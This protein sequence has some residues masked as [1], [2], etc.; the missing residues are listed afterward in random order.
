VAA[1]ID[2]IPQ[3]EYEDITL[4][5]RGPTSG[6]IRNVAVDNVTQVSGDRITS[7]TTF[8]SAL[9]KADGLPRS[10]TG[11]LSTWQVPII[12]NCDDLFT[13][14][15]KGKKGRKGKSKMPVMAID[16]VQ[17]I[18][19]EEEEDLCLVACSDLGK[20]NG[21]G[22]ADAPSPAEE[23]LD[24]ME[25]VAVEEAA[26]EEEKAGAKKPLVLKPKPVRPIGPD[27]EGA[28]N[29]TRR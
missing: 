9:T 14:T 4:P 19:L 8:Q 20:G 29:G 16:P 6:Y 11:V 26:A 27:V 24:L 7:P 18:T 2:F 12:Y 23:V 28:R 21:K 25:V 22:D 17:P 15:N 5:S 3:D 1:S 13:K 10:V